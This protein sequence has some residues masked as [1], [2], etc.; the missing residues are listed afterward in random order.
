MKPLSACP[1]SNPMFRLAP[2]MLKILY[3]QEPDG[4]VLEYDCYPN[5]HDRKHAY[6]YLLD[7]GYEIIGEN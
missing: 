3:T 1:V 5:R 7:K 4:E 2:D 6:Q